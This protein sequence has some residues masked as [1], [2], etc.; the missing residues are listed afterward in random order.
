MKSS[1][2]N[3]IP[4]ISNEHTES[5]VPHKFYQILLSG[6]PLLVSD[7]APM[8][9]MIIDENIGNYFEAENANNFANEVIAIHSD[10]KKAL[11]KAKIGQEKSL[12]GNLNWEFT[13]KNL[14]ALYNNL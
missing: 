10:Y 7:C 9:R 5:A 8:K 6:K 11:E 4:H 2:V 12:Q 3:I 14:V 13:S 1:D